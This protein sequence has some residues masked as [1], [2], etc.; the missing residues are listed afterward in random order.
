[1]SDLTGPLAQALT[2]EVEGKSVWWQ[3]T[4]ALSSSALL[5][6]SPAGNSMHPSKVGEVLHGGGEDGMAKVG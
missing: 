3:R 4:A 2:G 5:P 6:C 1:M